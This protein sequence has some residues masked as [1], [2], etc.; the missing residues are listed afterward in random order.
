VSIYTKVAF[1]CVLLGLSVFCESCMPTVPESGL[2]ESKTYKRGLNM[3]VN[4]TSRSYLIHV[5]KDYEEE[6]PL[7]LVVV[8]HGAFSTAR[9][10]ERQSGFSALADLH[11]FL[12]AYPNAAYGILGLLQHWN[13][14]HCCGK[15]ASDNLDD[16]GFLDAVIEDVQAQF[17]LDRDRIYMIGFSNG[18][19]MAFRYAA[20]RSGRIA[21][22]G[23][24]AASIGGKASEGDSIW[25]IPEPEHVVP[26]IYFHGKNDL[27]VPYAGGRSPKKG[28]EREY[29][30]VA[31]SI[32]F[33]VIRNRCLKP[34][35]TTM[36]CSGMVRKDSWVDKQDRNDVVLYSIQDWGHKWPGRYFTDGLDENNSLK[37]FDAG[38]MIWEFFRRYRRRSQDT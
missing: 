30:S 38:E 18:G 27:H 15:A 19:M 34:K 22:A 6:L 2:T 26:I 17:C 28:G 10:I 20:E 31:R 36:E 14:G 37:G 13:A 16:V 24:I 33:W 9:E 5:P 1:G 12:V 7:P 11:K 25:I 35:R 4:F 29:V 32:E 3:K 8:L 23:A 21:A